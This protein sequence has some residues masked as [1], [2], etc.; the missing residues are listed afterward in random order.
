[1]EENNNGLYNNDGYGTGGGAGGG[2]NDDGGKGGGKG[3]S[4]ASMVLGIIAIVF[5]CCNEYIAI[6]CGVVG[7][8]LSI[9]SIRNH[10]DGRGMATAGMV[11]CIVSLALAVLLLILSL[12]YVAMPWQDIIDTYNV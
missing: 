9:I 3:F 8:I 2:G 5:S 7:L 10:H 4:I 12:F 1:M 6:P 11:L